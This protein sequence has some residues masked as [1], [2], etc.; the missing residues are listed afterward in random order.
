MSRFALE[1]C[2][3]DTLNDLQ[4]KGEVDPS[5]SVVAAQFAYDAEG[6]S[7]VTRDEDF[8]KFPRI[9]LQTTS[10]THQP[11]RGV[12]RQ[13]IV[14]GLEAL[15]DLAAGNHAEVMSI[16]EGILVR[17]AIT[18]S[19]KRNEFVLQPE[20]QLDT[21][22]QAINY[23][24]KHKTVLVNLTVNYLIDASDLCHESTFPSASAAH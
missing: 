17:L 5:L 8:D 6:G 7:W 15:P 12:V 10:R 20:G 1:T 16:A 19:R 11:D 3:L 21:N 9:S 22:F 13:Q 14:I 4:A 23:S 18:V 24:S 2:L